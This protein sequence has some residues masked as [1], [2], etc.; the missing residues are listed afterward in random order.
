[1]NDDIE[2]VSSNE[3]LERL[4]REGR[5]LARLEIEVVIQTFPP[6]IQDEIRQDIAKPNVPTY[7]HKKSAEIQAAGRGQRTFVM[8][9]AKPIQM[10]YSLVE[11]TDGE[12]SV[13]DSFQY[14]QQAEDR[15]L[16]LIDQYGKSMVYKIKRH[17]KG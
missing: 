7:R 4:Q 11:I 16:Q 12:E 10:E 14:V 15:K 6:N 3:T 5:E 2:V 1:M 9:D 17:R 13:I 8:P